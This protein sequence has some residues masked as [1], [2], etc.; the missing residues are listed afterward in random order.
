MVEGLGD[1]WTGRPSRRRRRDNRDRRYTPVG[2]PPCLPPLVSTNKPE[3][4]RQRGKHP[5]ED[6]LPGSVCRERDVKS[7]VEEESD[8]GPTPH[9]YWEVRVVGPRAVTG[10]TG[11]SGTDTVTFIR[12]KE[13]ERDLVS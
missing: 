8:Y 13:F 2:Y 9:R 12:K 10:K 4:G 5:V 7:L 11:E 1:T 3:S 6:S